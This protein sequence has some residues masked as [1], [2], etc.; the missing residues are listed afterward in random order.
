M[1]NH[2]RARIGAKTG[3]EFIAVTGMMVLAGSASGTTIS[4]CRTNE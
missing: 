1:L 2:P 3:I 4:L